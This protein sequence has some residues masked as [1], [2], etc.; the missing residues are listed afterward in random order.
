MHKYKGAIIA[1]IGPMFGG[2]TSALLSDVRKMNIARYTVGLFKPTKDSRYSNSDVVNHDGEKLSCIN[3]H[4]FGD[5][6]DY[7]ENH[8]ALNIDVVAIDEIQFFEWRSKEVNDQF[9]NG[10][11]RASEWLDSAVT[12]TD[13]IDY[14]IKNK[15]TLIVSGLELDSSLKPFKNTE[16]LLPYATHIFKH[17]AVCVCCGNDATTSY[18]KVNKITQE[19]I[20]GKEMYEPRC[21]QCYLKGTK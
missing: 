13:F 19:Q 21:L 7:L 4:C 17:K 12:I 11:I 8:K 2:K 9:K 14:I 1:H 18:C 16:K 15:L 6:I 5:I 20:G 3:A 10:E